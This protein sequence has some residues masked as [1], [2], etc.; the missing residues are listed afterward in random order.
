VA[1]GRPPIGPSI[2]DHIDGPDEARKRVKLILEVLGGERSVDEACSELGIS[3]ARFYVLQTTMLTAAIEAF[4]P[5]PRGRPPQ[6]ISPDELRIEAL[7]QRNLELEHE[8]SLARVRGEIA[9]TMP[10]ALER[11]RKKKRGLKRRKS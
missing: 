5:K 3:P 1:G 6:T 7:M 8:L 9:M 4:A 11:G 2:V 10:E